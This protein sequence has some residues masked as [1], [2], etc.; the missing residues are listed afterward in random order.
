MDHGTDPSP[1][2]AV[3]TH[4]RA[5][6]QALRELARATAGSLAPM[7][8]ADIDQV[9]AHLADAVAAMPQVA[10]RLADTL[11]RA[12]EHYELA[13][14]GM[15]DDPDP[16]AAIAAATQRLRAVREPAT[17]TYRQVDGARRA[18]AHISANPRSTTTA[19]EPRR[20]THHRDLPA[21][22]SDPRGRHPGPSR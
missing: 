13:M 8:P 18:T 3:I 4:A 22:L 6:E 19:A 17:E 15:T 10:D 7:A 14:D 21:H 16:D 5:V 12:G 11:D 9:L 20:T 1:A 2:E